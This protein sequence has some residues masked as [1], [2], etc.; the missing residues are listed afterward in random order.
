MKK[1][2][3]KKS[4]SR[5]VD[6]SLFD[7]LEEEYE[8]KWQCLS[9]DSTLNPRSIAVAKALYDQEMSFRALLVKN[10]LRAASKQKGL[11]V[12]QLLL[13]VRADKHA[14]IKIRHFEASDARRLEKFGFLEEKKFV[15]GVF[16]FRI[17][18][19]GEKEIR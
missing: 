8:E 16:Y 15:N 3:P 2:V 7:G 1:R 4:V 10:F 12:S 14:M 19:A 18:E 17:T 9:E 6:M 13:L 5:M 11:R